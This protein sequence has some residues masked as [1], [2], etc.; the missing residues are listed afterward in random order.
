[1]VFLNDI[2]TGKISKEEAKNLQQHYE[3]YLKRVR[4]GNKSTEQRKIL[5]NI[6]IPFN[7]RDNVIKF[8]EGYSS[9]I[10]EAKKVSETRNRA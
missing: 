3:E 8:I 5:A 1:M 7:A 10:L 6:N 4:K 2:K 9:M